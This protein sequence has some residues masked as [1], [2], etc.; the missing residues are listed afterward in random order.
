MTIIGVTCVKNE[1]DIIEPFVRH[2]LFYLDKLIVLNHGST[3]GTARILSRLVD[4]G[5]PLLVEHD[6]S[7]GKFQGEKM[8][9]LMLRAVNDHAADWVLLLDADELIRCP[10]DRLPLPGGG[11]HGACLKVACRTYQTRETDDH[12]LI[13]PAERIR[14]RFA[15]EPRE[16][17]PLAERRYLLKAIIPRALALSP[18]ACVVQGNHFI[19]TSNQ[20]AAHEFWPGFDYAHFSLR[21]VGQYTS[22]IAIGTLQHIYRSSPRADLDS[23]YLNHLAEL[24]SDFEGFA[25]RFHERAPSYL[26]LAQNSRPDI[27]EDPLDYRGGPLR[28]TSQASDHTRLV[29]N[30]IGYAETLAGTLA[31]HAAFQVDTANMVEESTRLELRCPDAKTVIP[32]TITSGAHHAQT[33]RFSVPSS[34]PRSTWHLQFESLPSIVELREL[35]WLFEDGTEHTE[36]DAGASS[37]RIHILQNACHLHHDRYF[38]FIKGTKPA[39]IALRPPMRSEGQ[40]VVAL[41]LHFRSDPNAAANGSRLMHNDNLDRLIGPA[42][43]ILRLEQKIARRSTLSGALGFQFYRLWRAITGPAKGRG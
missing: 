29:S 11:D 37:A 31:K 32:R 27:I 4:E 12:S 14:H 24:R 34:P 41:E 35:R 21:S 16:D 6:P 39:S 42:E 5:L 33:V 3:D 1:E 40:R 9:R 15:K 2:N 7:L 23:F 36:P 25:R 13:N 17:R 30:L 10:E 43:R 38:T 18:G 8:T 26:E 20:E 28:H 22:K 19:V